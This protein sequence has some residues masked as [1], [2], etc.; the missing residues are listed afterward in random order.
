MAALTFYVATVWLANYFIAHVGDQPFP[1]GPHVIPVGFGYEAPSGVI[2]VGAALLLRDVVQRTLGWPPVILGILVGA[3]LSFF[4]APEFA[5]ASGAAFL[6]S[7]LMDF[8]VFTPLDQRGHTTAAVVASN[9]VGA[10]IDTFVFL[11]IAFSSIQF[12]QGQV[13][14]KLWVTLAVL[15]VLAWQRRREAVAS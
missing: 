1:G 4:I 5:F 11:W 10:V 6:I 3:G 9:T 2:W 12:W 7:E 14:G 13:I 8:G 15:P